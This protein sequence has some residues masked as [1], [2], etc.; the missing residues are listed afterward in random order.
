[1]RS[2]GLLLMLPLLVRPAPALAQKVPPATL[3]GTYT[4]QLQLSGGRDGGSYGLTG[5]TTLTLRPD[6]TWQ[7][8]HTWTLTGKE[9]GTFTG[10][11]SGRWSLLNDSMMVIKFDRLDHVAD[12]VPFTFVNQQ[13]SFGKRR[14]DGSCPASYDTQKGTFRIREEVQGL[15]DH[16]K[17]IGSDGLAYCLLQPYRRTP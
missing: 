3:A 5:P 10:E 13:L 16:I 12:T 17:S 8:K 1:M 4:S 7:R 15:P 14:N 11:G 9:S 6:S 2:V